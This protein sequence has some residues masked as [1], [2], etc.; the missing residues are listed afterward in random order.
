MLKMKTIYTFENAVMEF[1][2]DAQID[3]FNKAKES[4]VKEKGI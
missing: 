1:G 3:A 4:S 2:N